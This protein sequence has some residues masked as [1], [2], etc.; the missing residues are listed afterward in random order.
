MTR[1][2]LN[3]YLYGKGTYQMTMTNGEL[4]LINR[5]NKKELLKKI[6]K[7]LDLLEDTKNK[8]RKNKDGNARYK[9]L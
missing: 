1:L 2:N 9:N 3:I 5:A 8:R 4:E 7:I 6:S